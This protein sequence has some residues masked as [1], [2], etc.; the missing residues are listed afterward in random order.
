MTLSRR[1]ADLMA[2]TVFVTL[3]LVAVSTCGVA[4]WPMVRGAFTSPRDI[5]IAHPDIAIHDARA[6]IADRTRHPHKY[7]PFTEPE[8]LPAS[9]GI[10]NLRYAKVHDDH[11]DLVIARNPDWSAGARIWSVEHRPHHD[12]ATRYRDVYFFRYMREL[13]DAPDNI[14]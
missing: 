2:A 7:G 6:L 13:P 3:C 4:I 11:V 5:R 9:L 10:A 14:P 1:K 12:Q 8:S